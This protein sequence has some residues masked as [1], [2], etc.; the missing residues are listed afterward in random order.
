MN[1]MQKSF[2]E[3]GGLSNLNDIVNKHGAKKVLI[4]AGKKSF[5]L[6]GAQEKI[7]QILNNIEIFVFNDFE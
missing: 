1:N 2:M 4:V 6:S 3:T 7:K 5:A